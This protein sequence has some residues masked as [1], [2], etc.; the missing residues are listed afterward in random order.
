MGQIIIGGSQDPEL[1][2]WTDWQGW[3][4][5]VCRG[6][7]EWHSY[8]VPQS[9]VDGVPPLNW[10]E[11]GAAVEARIPGPVVKV[12]PCCTGHIG[13]K[14]EP[15]VSV[16]EPGTGLDVGLALG[17]AL[18]SAVVCRY[19]RQVEMPGM[20]RIVVNAVLVITAVSLLTI[21][22]VLALRERP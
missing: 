3:L 12:E 11:T 13:H 22:A 2:H 10:E 6:E 8:Q 17:L 4:T 7:Q 9:E 15:P 20:R 1:I 19:V 5:A 18:M 21:A 16:P 14:P